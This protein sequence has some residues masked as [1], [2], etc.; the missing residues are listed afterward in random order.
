MGSEPN[1][2]LLALLD[3]MS[4]ALSEAMPSTEASAPIVH[5][6]PAPLE[7]AP[8]KEEPSQPHSSEFEAAPRRTRPHAISTVT[9][10]DPFRP[11]RRVFRDPVPQVLLGPAVRGSTS[12]VLCKLLGEE[13]S[14]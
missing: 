14:P 3:G 1:S 11:E 4:S 6:V 9:R 12:S 10:R 5:E 13:A 8:K 2:Q 7:S